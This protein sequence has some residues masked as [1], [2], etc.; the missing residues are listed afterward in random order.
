MNQTR[1]I[2]GGSF[3]PPLTAEKI[4]DYKSLTD[5]CDDRKCAGYMNDLIKMVEVFFETPESHERPQKHPAGVGAVIPLET[6]EVERIWDHVPW[7]EEC[8]LIGQAFDSLTG[9]TR[10]AAYHLL[11][12]AREL[13]K[14]RETC[15]CD[16]L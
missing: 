7:A 3:A 12:Y 10:N 14:V 2:I 4:A 1:K 6:S 9:E 5:S 16:K 13:T 15:T 11:W 8:D